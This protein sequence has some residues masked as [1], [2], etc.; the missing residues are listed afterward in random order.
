VTRAFESFLFG[1]MISFAPKSTRFLTYCSISINS[2]VTRHR[3]QSL[4]ISEIF[5]KSQVTEGPSEWAP[6]M[7]TEGQKKIFLLGPIA[8]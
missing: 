8:C 7:V 3:S 6:D 2:D 4:K 5:R 1:R